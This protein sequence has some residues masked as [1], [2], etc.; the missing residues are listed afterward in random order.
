[1]IDALRRTVDY[2]KKHVLGFPGIKLIA[3]STLISVLV[4]FVGLAKEATIA[5]YLGVSATTDFYVISLI[6]VTFFVGPVVGALSPILTR[7]IRELCRT[8]VTEPGV[9]LVTR[10]LA[11]S[12]LMMT[13]LTLVVFLLADAL[14]PA[15]STA[16]DAATVDVHLR[17]WLMPIGVLSAVT[18]ITC[19]ILTAEE[20]F[21]T[22]SSMP[23]LV[24]FTVIISCVLAPA[25][26]V[27]PLIFIG[28]SLGYLL[29]ATVAAIIIRK[30]LFAPSKKAL[31]SGAQ[32]FFGLVKQWP[33]LAISGLLINA[34]IVIDQTM[35]TLAGDGAVAMINFGNRV[36]LG[37]LTLGSILWTVIF[38]RFIDN[39]LHKQFVEL[40]WMLLCVQTIVIVLGLTG[41]A[42][43]AF[44]SEWIVSMLFERGAFTQQNT[45]TVAI[46]QAIYFLHIPFYISFFI[47]ARILN[48]FEKLRLYFLSNLTMLICNVFFNILFMNI[49]GVI[50]I[51]I[52]TLVSYT[53]MSAVWFSVALWLTFKAQNQTS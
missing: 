17:L 19:A 25:H 36:T 24:S 27:I 15:Q 4:R 21:A 20:K 40:R 44:S 16:Q 38:P 45:K 34:C 9:I 26:L 12:L 30:Y 51:A 37:I 41:C 42:L 48:A 49:F 6:M 10:I 52:A 29:E 35:A 32:E 7:K 11:S 13:V 43:L 22:Q 31:A 18:V 53:A 23:V 50:G 28:T 14:F 3:V 33:A 1:M 2:T 8:G 5:N 46:I 47:S 39:V